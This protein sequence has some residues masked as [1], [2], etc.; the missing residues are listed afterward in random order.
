M[1]A[2]PPPDVTVHMLV[3]M[4][5]ANEHVAPLLQK[6]VDEPGVSGIHPSKF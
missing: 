5:G 4:S 3:D 1:K 2:P 6:K